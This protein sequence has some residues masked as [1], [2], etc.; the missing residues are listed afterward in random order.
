M[1]TRRGSDLHEAVSTFSSLLKYRKG[2]NPGDAQKKASSDFPKRVS[3]SKLTLR[4]ASDAV[5]RSGKH[6][7]IGIATYSA[8][9]LNLLD[10]LEKSLRNSASGTPNVEVFDVLE[11]DKMSDF[12]RFIP[13]LHGVVRTP[14]IGVIFDGKLIDH[15]TGLS[16][17]MSVLRRFDV[18]DQS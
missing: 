3:Q 14:V 10:Q 4:K 17:V 18:L 7:I 12:E 13:G 1:A 11:C 5:P 6:F 15:A 2:K 16:E 8:D 9:E